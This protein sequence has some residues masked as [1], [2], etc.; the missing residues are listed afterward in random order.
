[1]KDQLDVSG[2][3]RGL[4]AHQHR[5]P[6]P[7]GEGT[8]LAVG[9]RHP[10]CPNRRSRYRWV[11]RRALDWPDGGLDGLNRAQPAPTVTVTVAGQ[12]NPTRTVAELGAEMRGPELKWTGSI[13][14]D[15]I[16]VVGTDVRPRNLSIRSRSRE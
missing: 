6:G 3:D 10:H 4:D 15:G 14:G 12:P 11:R 5:L 2:F 8:P 1:M 16:F 9:C 7:S 13:P